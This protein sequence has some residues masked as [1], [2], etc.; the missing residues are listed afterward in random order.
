MFVL[1]EFDVAV[2]DEEGEVV[3]GHVGRLAGQQQDTVGRRRPADTG[4]RRSERGREGPEPS[5][6]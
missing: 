2:P 4:G 3:P 5:S 1:P 6:S